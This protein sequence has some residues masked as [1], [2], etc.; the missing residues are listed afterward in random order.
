MLPNIRFGRI[1]VSAEYSADHFRSNTRPTTF[2]VDHNISNLHFLAPT[3][4]GADDDG[5]G[6]SRGS[7][8]RPDDAGG[9]GSDKV[10]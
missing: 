4:E 2:S 1:F 3:A 8:N 5:K 7:D 10:S 9:K 6:A